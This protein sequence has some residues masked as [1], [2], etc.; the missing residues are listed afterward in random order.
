MTP[1]RFPTNRRGRALLRRLGRSLRRDR[2]GLALTEFAFALPILMMLMSSGLELGNYVISVKR[3]GDLAVLVADNSSRMGT[4]NGLAISQISEADINDVFTGAALQSGPTNIQQHGR[5]ILSSLQRNADGGNWIAWQRCFGQLPVASAYGQ[6]GAG[7]TGTGF[8]GM[9]PAGNRIEAPPG[10]A[11]M[12]VEI[13]YEYQ[14]IVPI[15]TLPV[16]RITE[17]AVFN[18][19]DNRDLAQIMNPEGVTPATCS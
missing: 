2:R 11:V 5:I 19:R 1:R 17:M 16:G 8:A 18:V 9:G 6:Q 14:R 7:A 15:I 3:I 13:A 10:S 12:V 4:R